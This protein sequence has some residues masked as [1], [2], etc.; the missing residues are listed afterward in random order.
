M[1]RQRSTILVPLP[2]PEDRHTAPLEERTF[3]RLH[4]TERQLE[5]LDLVS[6]GKSSRDI[7]TILNI[8]RKT[9]DHLVERAC[10]NL[11][12]RTRFQAVLKV[13]DLGL[14]SAREASPS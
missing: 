6:K 11:E 3:A 9:V 13:R 8:S 2:L 10:D 12:V 1:P 14:L 5:I 7:G 4:I